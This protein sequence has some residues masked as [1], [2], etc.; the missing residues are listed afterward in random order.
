[1]EI[2]RFGRLMDL[3]L[4]MYKIEIYINGMKFKSI[5]A[6]KPMK[7]LDQAK[8]IAQDFLRNKFQ[9][10]KYERTAISVSFFRADDGNNIAKIKI[11]SKEL[12]RDIILEG[13]L[14]DGL[15]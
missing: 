5:D 14:K 9:L 11:K 6:E 8:S 1:M 10:Q 4:V 15:V 2:L 13:L 7:N 3:K 12:S